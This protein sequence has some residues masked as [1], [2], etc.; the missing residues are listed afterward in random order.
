MELRKCCNHPFLING[1]ETNEMDNL[2]K[3]LLEDAKRG[4]L[5]PSALGASPTGLV[6]KSLLQ[7]LFERKRMLD[8]LIPSSGKMVLVDKLLPK[9]KKEGHKVLI[10]SQMVKMIDLIEEFCE[11]R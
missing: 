2:E 1:V 10:F 11:F 7:Q 8:V 9:L 5:D 6:K 4:A 3:T